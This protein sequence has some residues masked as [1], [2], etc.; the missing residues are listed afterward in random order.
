MITPGGTIGILGGGQLG[1]MLAMAAAGLGYRCHIYAPGRVSVAAE[2]SAEF[3]CASWTDEGALAQFAE[4]CDV[5]TFEFENVPVAPLAAI[6]A[7]L[8][9]HS[10]ALEI[11]QDRLREKGFAEELGGKTAPYAPVHDS[12]SLAAAINRIGA[13][14]ILKT[15]ADGYDGKGQ[16]RIGSARD[17]DSIRLP[18][19]ATIYEGLVNFSAEFSVIVVRGQNGE[20]RFWDSAE[21]VTIMVF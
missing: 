2:V 1:R 6:E 5:V 10:R 16:W 15:R 4:A 20:V 12:E 19:A 8:A 14:G 17:A 18:D 3:T 9:P 13:P 21:N 11:A 7:K